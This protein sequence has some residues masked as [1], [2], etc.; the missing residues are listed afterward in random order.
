MRIAV[1]AMGGD[2]APEAIISGAVAAAR[3][4]GADVVLVGREARVREELARHRGAP[5]LEIV[6]APEVIE[7]HEPPAMALRRKR[8]ASIVVAIELLKAGRADA[9]VTAGHTGAAMGAA[10]LGLGRVPGVDRPAIAAVLPT[11]TALPAILLD[12]GANVDCKPHHLLQFALMGSVY[13]HRVLGAASP[14]VGLLSNGTEEGKGSELTLAATPLLRASG[15]NFVGNVEA[16]DFFLGVAD[17]VVCDGFVGNVAMKFGQGLALAIRNI[18]KDELRGLRGK[19][20]RLYLAPLVGLIR[21]L[22]RRIDYREYGGG[23]ALGADGGGSVAPRRSNARA[24]R[25]AVRVAAEA[26]SHGF[27]EE[28]RSRMPQAQDVTLERTP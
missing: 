19:L 23:A 17:V 13:A 21:R 11:Q 8:R 15:L 26:V 18:A 10:L 20:L 22:Y 4:L 2:Q 12:V 6:D 16:R 27:V 25:N 14:R 24:L 3:E 5:A 7:M 1:D 9:V 28:L